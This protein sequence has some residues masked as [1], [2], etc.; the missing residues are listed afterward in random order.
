[1]R[2]KQMSCITW[3]IPQRYKLPT[4]RVIKAAKLDLYSKSFN[5]DKMK[6]CFW[7]TKKREMKD[8]DK[9]ITPFKKTSI[10]IIDRKMK[11]IFLNIMTNSLK[12]Y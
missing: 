2:K 4:N 12:K 5:L 8:T 6:G 3:E 9:R 7:R 1:M 10:A 11:K